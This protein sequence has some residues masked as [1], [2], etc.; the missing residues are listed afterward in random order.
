M[1]LYYETSSYLVV[2]GVIQINPTF[3]EVITHKC[4]NLVLLLKY[5]LNVVLALVTEYFYTLAL[6]L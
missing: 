5:C 2:D 1:I 4:T 3:T 6:L